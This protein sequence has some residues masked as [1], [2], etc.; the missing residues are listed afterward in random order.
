M[1]TEELKTIWK[2][3]EAIAHIHGWDFSHIHGRYAEE[4]ELPWDY[5]TIV[6]QYL[7][8]DAELLDYDTGG[9]EF[10]LSLKHP[11]HRTAA[12]EGYPPNVALCKERLLPLGINFRACDDAAQI[13]FDDTS[14]DLII[15]RHGDFDAPELHRLLKPGGVFVTE[16]VGCNNDHELVEMVL[17]GTTDPHP[18]LNLETQREAFEE[19]GFQVIRAEKAFLPIRF[20]DIGAFVWFARIIEWEFPG[21]SVDRCFDKLLE[22]QALLERDG[23]VEGTIHRYLLVARKG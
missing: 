23:A 17:P 4:D 21:F 13:P 6:R 11:Y 12:T 14:F 16:Q 3:E 1:A 22:M 5:E 15:N 10:L 2:Q 18:E 20:Y 9:G 7:R 8:D 19:A